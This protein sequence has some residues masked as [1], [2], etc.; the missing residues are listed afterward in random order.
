MKTELLL[1]FHIYGMTISS[2]KSDIEY[3]SLKEFGHATRLTYLDP[4][5]SSVVFANIFFVGCLVRKRFSVLVD[6]KFFFAQC[7]VRSLII[8]SE[9]TICVSCSVCFKH[10]ELLQLAK[11]YGFVPQ[12][13]HF[14]THL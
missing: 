12:V 13:L 6:L 4:Q 11:K 14:F 8:W 3:F 5:V 10:E 9:K 7:F 1:L 2:M